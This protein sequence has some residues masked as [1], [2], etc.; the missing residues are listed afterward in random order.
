MSRPLDHPVLSDA[1]STSPPGALPTDAATYGQLINRA[2]NV[3]S[4]F[5]I[6]D[7]R[8]NVTAAPAVAGGTT[9]VASPGG[10][11]NY[12]R[13]N[14]A[15]PA[16]SATGSHAIAIGSAALGS[17]TN[18]VAMGNGPN[19]TQSSSIALGAS[20]T[21]TGVN[22][23]AIG[24]GMVATGTNSVAIGSGS[25]AGEANTVSFGSP[26]NERRI[27]GVASGVNLTDVAT[28][29]QLQ[30]AATGLESQITGI[31]TQVDDNRRETRAG[32]ALAL[33]TAGSCKRS[34]PWQSVAR[35]RFRQLQRIVGPRG[36]VGLCGV[37]SMAPQRRVHLYPQ[38]N[39]CGLVAGASWTVN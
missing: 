8:L 35:R 12:F 31:Q 7:Q 13:T 19:A 24:N 29:G 9:I 4:R 20:A 26:G 28:F 25:V 33:A 10:A 3:D 38:V 6:V 17:G 15:G 37:G 14:T 1:S 2:S 22:A 34:A 5:A 23:V 21:S 16:S 39:D 32:T 30:R 11:S 27:T 18:A 36:R